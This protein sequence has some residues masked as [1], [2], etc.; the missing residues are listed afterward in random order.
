MF[1]C[2]SLLDP[3]QYFDPL[4]NPFASRVDGIAC[5]PFAR[6]RLP[7][8]RLV[9]LGDV[10]LGDLG[11]E[12]VVLFVFLIKETAAREV[13]GSPLPSCLSAVPQMGRS[14]AP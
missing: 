14:S 6:D 12:H 13:A 7:D 10:L 4:L 3:L 5:C 11:R 9:E 2:L 8:T 1:A